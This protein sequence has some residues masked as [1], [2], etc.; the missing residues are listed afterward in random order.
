M[1]TEELITV[2]DTISFGMMILIIVIM[3]ASIIVLLIMDSK[4]KKTISKFDDMFEKLIE[5]DSRSGLQG[6]PIDRLRQ[7]KLT[8][9]K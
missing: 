5:K 6:G 9:I 2:L 1:K 3:I 7:I 8:Q 4:E